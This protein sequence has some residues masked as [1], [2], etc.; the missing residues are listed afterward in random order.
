MA[1]RRKPTK[2]CKQ[3]GN[4]F[5]GRGNV[6]NRRGS[7]NRG[8]RGNAGL[9]KHKFSWITVY[10]PDY[11][12]KF[13][14]HRPQGVCTKVPVVHLYDIDRKIVLGQL[15]KKDGKFAFS[16]EGK[17]LSTG[18]INHAVIIKALAWSKNCEEKVKKMGGEISKIA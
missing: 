9:H 4:R 11:F 13:G 18:K 5:F 3:L 16:F 17:V 10:D 7:G 6:K 1:S 8:G 14:F 12:G 15:E 2:K